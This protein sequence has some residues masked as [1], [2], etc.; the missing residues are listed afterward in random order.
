MG[1]DGARVSRIEELLADQP[2]DVLANLLITL[3]ARSPLVAQQ[4]RMVFGPRDPIETLSECRRLLR[5]TINLHT[6]GYGFGE[7]E[8]VGGVVNGSTPVADLAASVA[9][10][11]PVLAMDI[12]LLLVEEMVTLL[13]TADDSDGLVGG[14]IEDALAAI[15]AVIGDEALSADTKG[16]LVSK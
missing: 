2:C 7:Y 6:D 3:A 12:Y 1:P 15:D 13:Q 8:A 14:A 4:I 5:E 9:A 16:S 10:Q 11:D